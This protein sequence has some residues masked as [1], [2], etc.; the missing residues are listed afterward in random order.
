MLS[1]NSLIENGGLVTLKKTEI[2]LNFVSISIVIFSEICD[3]LYSAQFLFR[4]D[5]V[6][7]CEIYSGK[8]VFS[9]ETTW[10]TLLDK[11]L[12]YD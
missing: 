6:L 12:I 9:V 2:Y 8:E 5:I 10:S 11:M 7:S 3:V 4:V 1:N